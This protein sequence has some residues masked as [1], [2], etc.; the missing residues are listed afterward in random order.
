MNETRRLQIISISIQAAAW[1][2][3]MFGGPLIT[4]LPDLNFKGLGQAIPHAFHTL[5]IPFLIYLVNYFIL[6]PLCAFRKDRR[7]LFFVVNISFLAYEVVKAMLASR[8]MHLPPFS[9]VSPVRIAA[10]GAAFQLMARVFI[11]MI[12]LGIRIVERYEI[13]RRAEEQ[14][15]QKAT[16]AELTMLKN[17]LNPHFL[18]NTLNNISSLTQIDADKAQ[19]SIGQLSDLLRYTLYDTDAKEVP[20]SGEVEFLHNYIALMALRCNDLTS[21]EENLQVPSGDVKVAPLLFISLVENAF[22]HGVNSR[23]ESFVKVDLHADGGDLLFCCTNSKFEKKGTDRAGSGIGLENLKRRLE[24]IYPD[25][26]E[27]S[28]ESS[29]REYK[30]TVRLKGIC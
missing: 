10:T 18:F 4:F 12:A 14:S 21:I 29:E 11:I 22:K 5:S 7:W 25:R 17:Q 24:L 3:L 28:T 1:I 30:V 19:S 13:Q 20:I 2:L 23:Y 6:V 16:E 26:Y 8:N 27:Y 15:R 9:P